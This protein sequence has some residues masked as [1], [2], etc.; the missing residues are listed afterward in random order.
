MFFK[1]ILILMINIFSINKTNHIN[2]LIWNNRVLIIKNHKKIDFSM[3]IDIFMQEFDERNF[4]IVYLKDKNTFIN[5][6]KMPKLFSKSIINKIKNIN[7]N[8]YFILIGKDGQVKSSYDSRIKIEKILSDVDRMPMRK[9][10][11]KKIEKFY[12]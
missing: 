5:N 7:S 12:E 1:A 3:K 10:E 9:Y 11:M 4:T 8:H 6:R 2:D